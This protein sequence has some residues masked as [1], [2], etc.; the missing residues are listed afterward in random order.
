MQ[1]KDIIRLFDPLSYIRIYDKEEEDSIYEGFVLD[2]PWY[3]LNYYVIFSDDCLISTRII[4]INNRQE[5]A[6]VIDVQD[7]KPERYTNFHDL[8][9]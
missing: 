2:I 4:N 6:F 5:A 1:L 3:L 9:F 7:K 8:E